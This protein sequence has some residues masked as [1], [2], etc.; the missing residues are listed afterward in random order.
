MDDEWQRK[1]ATAQDIHAHARV[2][3]WVVSAFNMLQAHEIIYS[4]LF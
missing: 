4:Y 3:I 1:K 2:P